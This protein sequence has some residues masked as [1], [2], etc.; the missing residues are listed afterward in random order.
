MTSSKLDE[1]S[2][3]IATVVGSIALE[4]ITLDPL[5]IQD[6]QR[7]ERGELTTEEALKNAFE[8]VRQG[9]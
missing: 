7:I 1:V 4:G 8:R 2:E 6:M 5:V 9:Q 3:T